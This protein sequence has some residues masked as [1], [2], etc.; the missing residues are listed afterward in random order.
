MP[1]QAC[2]YGSGVRRDSPL[3]GQSLWEALITPGKARS[4]VFY[5][6]LFC[7]ILPIIGSFVI[8]CATYILSGVVER[9]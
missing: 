4:S 3:E 6:I 7:L 2:L 1:K 8:G 5:F 9:C